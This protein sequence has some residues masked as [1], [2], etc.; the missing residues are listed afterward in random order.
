MLAKVGVSSQKDVMFS[1]HVT[2]QNLNPHANSTLIFFC[3]LLRYSDI[4]SLLIITH[5]LSNV[6]FFYGSVEK[7]NL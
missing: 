7:A 1:I 4:Q 5:P 2:T 3:L 6:V